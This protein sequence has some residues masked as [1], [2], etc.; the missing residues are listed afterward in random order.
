MKAL[1]MKM[2]MEITGLPR[3]TIYFYIKNGKFPK[4]IKLGPKSSAWLDEEVYGW[5]EE[6]KRERA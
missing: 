3:S 6:R 2:V 1:R 4:P 5:I